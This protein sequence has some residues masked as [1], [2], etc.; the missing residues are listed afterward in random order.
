MILK[1]A[2]DWSDLQRLID[3]CKG[4]IRRQA[5]DAHRSP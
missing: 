3:R 5:G 4:E 2:G 1:I